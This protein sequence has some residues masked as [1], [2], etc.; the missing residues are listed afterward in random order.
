MLLASNRKLSNGVAHDVRAAGTRLRAL[1]ERRGLTQ[2]QLAHMVGLNTYT[3]VSQLE[4]GRG[5]IPPEH[6]AVWAKA[7]GVE[8]EELARLCLHA[9]DAVKSSA[10]A[11]AHGG[12]RTA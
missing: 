8:P 6:G 2:R 7:L 9:D 5:N 3:I 4:N 12:R 11:A 1:R 10:R